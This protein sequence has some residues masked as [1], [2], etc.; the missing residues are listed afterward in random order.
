[1]SD[2]VIP[3]RAKLFIGV[4]TA[5]EDILLFAEERLFR[6]YGPIDYRSRKL[7]FSHTD[8]YDS[9]GKNLF[10][11]F[12]SFERLIPR[13]DIVTVKLATNRLEKKLTA[14]IGEKGPARRINIDPGYLTLSNVYLASCKEFFHRTYLWRGVYLENEYRYVGRQFQPWDWTYPDYKKMDYLDF[15]HQ[16]RALYRKQIEK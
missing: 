2:P 12:Y 16:V 3:P 9:I 4:L 15:F 14:R 11:V 8:Y 10:K 1:M 6:K 5:R 7:P 13:E